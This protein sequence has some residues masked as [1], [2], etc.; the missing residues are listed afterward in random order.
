MPA[1]QP[2][3]QAKDAHA[4]FKTVISTLIALHAIIVILCASSN[5]RPSALQSRLLAILRPYVEP[6]ALDWNFTPFFLTHGSPSDLDCVVEFLSPSD[7]RW[8]PISAG[9]RWAWESQSRLQRW[10]RFFAF[11]VETGEE[12]AGAE[13]ALAVADYVRQ[14]HGLM[15][16]RLRLRRIRSMSWQTAAGRD[17]SAPQDPLAD[18]YGEMLYEAAVVSDQDGR[19]NIV[20]IAAQGRPAPPSPIVEP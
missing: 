9:Q 8:H 2:I 14:R 4:L 16:L 19:L 10:A 1:C 13:L 15:P 18:Y 7:G 5:Y 3:N 17:R 12:Q 6:L 20:P 11:H